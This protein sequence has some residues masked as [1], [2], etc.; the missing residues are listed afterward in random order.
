MLEFP[1]GE[2]WKRMLSSARADL[3]QV[4]VWI[5]SVHEMESIAPDLAQSLSAEEQSR[6]RRFRRA[7]D[8]LQ[9][10]A[11]H[12]LM[13]KLCADWFGLAMD[14]LAI[15]T[16]TMG[17]PFLMRTEALRFVDFDFNVSHQGDW[18]LL[19]WSPCQRVGVDLEE[20]VRWQSIELHETAGRICA[21][22]EVSLLQSASE[23]ERARI[24]TEIWVRKE[25]VL[26]ADGAGL[27]QDPRGFSVV[28]AKS[29]A[30]GWRRT[31]QLP[32]A[33][34]IWNIEAI[35]MIPGT[36]AAVAIG[37]ACPLRIFGAFQDVRKSSSEPGSG[38]KCS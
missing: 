29:K 30:F 11:G 3:R 23:P 17:R 36:C 10:L 25:A 24:F 14:D 33:S 32:G 38:Y 34:E 2:F 13:R 37:S 9:F 22:E 28:E 5:Q 4:N 21:S 20:I 6:A 8:R 16:T 27:L 12:F 15:E 7:P 35:G 18:L 1:A 31:I 26:K 19:V